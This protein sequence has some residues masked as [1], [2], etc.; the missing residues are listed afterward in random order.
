MQTKTYGQPANTSSPQKMKKCNH[1]SQKY[2]NMHSLKVYMSL[3]S[4]CFFSF[5]NISDIFVHLHYPKQ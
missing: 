5:P 2:W 3:S 1:S 4:G